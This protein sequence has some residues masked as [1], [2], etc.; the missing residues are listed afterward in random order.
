MSQKV[1]SFLAERMASRKPLCVMCANWKVDKSDNQQR[2]MAA[3]GRALC[4]IDMRIDAPF[5]YYRHPACEKMVRIS[6]EA[7]IKRMEYLKG[8]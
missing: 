6:V 8:K 5:L 3:T 2:D 4:S 7:E 1:D